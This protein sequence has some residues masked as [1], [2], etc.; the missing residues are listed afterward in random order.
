MSAV[1]Q[2]WSRIW[3]TPLLIGVA[4]MVTDQVSKH[5]VERNLGAEPY[6]RI[7]SLIDGWLVIVYARNTGIAFGV[8][9]NLPQLFTIT[10]LLI[11]GVMIYAYAVHLPN[12]YRIIQVAIGLV[13]GGSLGNI[14]D[15]LRLGYVIDFVGVGQFPIFN[16]ADSAITIGIGVL[17]VCLIVIDTTPSP[18]PPPHDDALLSELLRQPIE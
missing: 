18:P 16:L 4:V 13:C 3:I 17:A 10:S 14:L 15:R 7:I 11:T 6:Q 8:L 12:Q 5:W 1:P 9:R 2:Q